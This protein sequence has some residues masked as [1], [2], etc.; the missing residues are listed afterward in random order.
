MQARVTCAGA[1]AAVVGN[2]CEDSVSRF[3]ATPYITVLQQ[4]L[5]HGSCEEKGQG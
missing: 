5:D 4:R 3:K 2:V 1:G